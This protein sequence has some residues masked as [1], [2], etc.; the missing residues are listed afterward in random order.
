MNFQ[1]WGC[2]L[3]AKAIADHGDLAKRARIALL[4]SSSQQIERSAPILSA[5][6]TEGR[7]HCGK[8]QR[9][10][11]FLL[12]RFLDEA[13]AIFRRERR[14]PANE[15]ARTKLILRARVAGPCA[16]LQ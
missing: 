13:G 12:C 8:L 5:A 1:I 3:I 6:N 7:Q 14:I 16:L 15:Q 2:Q 11:I 9:V 10:D 4:R